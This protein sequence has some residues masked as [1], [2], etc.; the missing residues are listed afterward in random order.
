M[1]KQGFYLL[2]L[3]ATNGDATAVADEERHTPTSCP[4]LH[5]VFFAWAYCLHKS[6]KRD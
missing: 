1:Y 2:L 3:V 5:F 6:L 4:R